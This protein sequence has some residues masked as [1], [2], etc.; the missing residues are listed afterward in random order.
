MTANPF[1]INK[2]QNILLLGKAA[3]DYAIGEIIYSEDADEILEKYGD[4]DLTRAFNIAQN[5]GVKYIFCMNLQ[6]DADYFNAAESL[7]QGDFTYIVFVSLFLSDIFQETYNGGI[8]HSTLAY[9]LGNIGLNCLSTF[10]VTDKHASLYENIDAFMGDMQKQQ[11]KFLSACSTRANLQNIIF[12]ANNLKDHPVATTPLAAALCGPINKY[13]TSD[14]FGDS[15][16]HIDRWD[17][18]GSMAYFRSNITRETTVENLLNM[19]RKNE[20]EK[21][22]F[23]D[24]ILKYIQREMDFQEFKGRKYTEYQKLLFRQK[25]EKYYESIKGF[26]IREYKINSVDAYRDEPGTV[27]ML[28][29]ADVLPI[30]CLEMCS[31]KKEVEV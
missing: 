14:R 18:P 5:M 21:V 6:K 4:S 23:V 15:I 8:K 11:E 20:P 17:N 13:P 10:I 22:V 31:V 28:A 1:M 9:F 25:I 2:H 16:F 7:K 26:I 29:R 3:T 30:N 19:L 27:V 24:R 12:V